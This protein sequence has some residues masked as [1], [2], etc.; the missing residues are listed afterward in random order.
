MSFHVKR[1]GISTTARYGRYGRDAKIQSAR[2]LPLTKKFVVSSARSVIPFTALLRSVFRHPD[3]QKILFFL[4][5]TSSLSKYNSNRLNRVWMIREC[6]DQR[7][8]S[9]IEVWV[10]HSGIDRTSHR[11]GCGLVQCNWFGPWAFRLLC[12]LHEDFGVHPVVC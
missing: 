6:H 2:A 4:A 9:F 11:D 12:G 1:L 5:P 8:P 3:I 7:L 10:R